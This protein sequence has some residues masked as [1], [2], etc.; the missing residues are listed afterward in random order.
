M[1]SKDKERQKEYGKKYRSEHREKQKEYNKKYRSEHR[2]KL[3]EQKKAHEAIPAVKAGQRECQRKWYEKNKD[4]VITRA[5]ANYYLRRYGVTI[6]DYENL[7]SSSGGM[8]YIC[9]CPP[10]PW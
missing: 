9:G 4:L 5:R 1:S 7:Y 8:C 2:E 6:E 10:P 3:F